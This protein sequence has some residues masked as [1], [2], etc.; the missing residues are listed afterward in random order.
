MKLS[1]CIEWLYAA[2]TAN[3]ADRI[4]LAK[5]DGLDAIEFWTWSDKD[6]AQ[7][8]EAIRSTGMEVSSIVAE[9]MISLTD[10]GNQ[11]AFLEGLKSSVETAVR[12]GAPVLI[13]QAGAELDRIS[14]QN[15]KS[16]LIET[17]ALAGELL[18][19]SDVRV[20]LE[21]LNTLVDHPGYFLWSTKEA[22]EIVAATGRQEVGIVYDIYH[23]AVMGEDTD[24]VIGTAIDRVFHLHVAD[25]PGRHQPGTGKI[26]LRKR[27][28]WL[29][30]QGYSGFLGLEY[31]PIAS[32]TASITQ[33]R[34][35]L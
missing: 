28:G 15:Q 8:E 32:T 3:F 31:R 7:V 14:R 11:R 17:L 18:E 13:V 23:S 9:P 5:Q 26:D 4:S 35:S 2:E 20:G 12:L 25:Y 6:L 21:P 29:A 19:G 34:A 1:A 24:A 33:C 16:A 27:V 22:L 10:I 30:E